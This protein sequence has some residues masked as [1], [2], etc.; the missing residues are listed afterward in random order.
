MNIH[1]HPMDIKDQPVNVED[2]EC[3]EE[4]QGEHELGSQFNHSFQMGFKKVEVLVVEQRAL[5]GMK[6]STKAFQKMI[7]LRVLKIDNLHIS[8][9][10]ELLSKELRWLSWKGCPLKC[11]PSNF[12]AE[13][14]VVLNMRGSNIQEF[15]L[16]LQRLDLSDCKRLRST[17]N[18]KGSRSLETLW[19]QNCSSLKEIPPSIGNLDRLS[20]LMKQSLRI[21]LECNE[22]PSGLVQQ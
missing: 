3:C 1:D 15:G 14:L 21:N 19:L 12:P 17:P 16:N 9:D 7:K 22:I 18:F 11:V 2:F 6:L 5:K 20:C 4:M 8:G 10:V 13:K